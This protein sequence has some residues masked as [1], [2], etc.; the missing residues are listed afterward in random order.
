MREVKA[1][2]ELRS[3][4]VSYGDRSEVSGCSQIL[5]FSEY[6][7]TKEKRLANRWVKLCTEG[8]KADGLARRPHHMMP[9]GSFL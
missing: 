1:G 3:R 9:S 2:Y 5:Y 7:K 6:V 4:P 8:G